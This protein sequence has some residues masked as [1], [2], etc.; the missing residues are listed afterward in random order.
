MK[1]TI[2]TLKLDDLQTKQ[3]M[4]VLRAAAKLGSDSDLGEV[5]RMVLPTIEAQTKT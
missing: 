2:T 3:L 5:A 4:A 1:K